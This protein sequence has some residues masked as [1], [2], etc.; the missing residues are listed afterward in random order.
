LFK[1]NSIYFYS[2]IISIRSEG[3]HTPALEIFAMFFHGK[4]TKAPAN[5]IFLNL[6]NGKT[7]FIRVYIFKSDLEK[8]IDQVKVQLNFK[9]KKPDS[10]NQ[11]F[12]MKL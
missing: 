10:E 6:A 2:D 12:Y 5:R 4:I 1:S 11:P 3:I 9:N 8:A 7:I